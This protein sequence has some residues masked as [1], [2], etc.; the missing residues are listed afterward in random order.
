[1][2]LG[3]R[4]FLL[5]LLSSLVRALIIIVVTIAFIAKGKSMAVVYLIVADFVFHALLWGSVVRQKSPALFFAANVTYSA[6][7]VAAALRVLR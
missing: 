2:A 6:A 3:P 7:V 4:Q 5:P 1:M